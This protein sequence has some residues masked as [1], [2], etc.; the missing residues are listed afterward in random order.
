LP[1]RVG[2][3]RDSMLKKCKKAVCFMVGMCVKDRQM[4]GLKYIWTDI[5]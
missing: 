2:E 3:L 1:E 5:I 4:V